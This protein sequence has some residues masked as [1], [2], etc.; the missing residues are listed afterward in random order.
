MRFTKTKKAPKSY[1][2]TKADLVG[3]S[4]PQRP[5]KKRK[6]SR[7]RGHHVS[8]GG[9]VPQNA[10]VMFCDGCCFP[11]NPGRAGWAFVNCD[12]GDKEFGGIE[13]GT[14]NIAE[15]T[16]AL[17]ALE[18]IL[19]RETEG[20][21]VFVYSD[22]QYV[23]RGVMEWS[24][25]WEKTGWSK[26]DGTIKNLEL[27]KNLVDLRKKTGAEFRWVK[28]HNG[29]HWNEMVDSLAAEGAERQIRK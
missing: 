10:I 8:A 20:R 23:V 9:N 29:N 2:P 12:T 7:N 26:G 25:K 17:R 11:T 21:P 22:S 18:Y 27:W 16:A 3:T 15:L 28:G 14:N 5:K 4:P 6:A 1:R 24:K 19:E 13:F